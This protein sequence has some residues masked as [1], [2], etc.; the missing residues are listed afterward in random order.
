MAIFTTLAILAAASGQEMDGA[1]MLAKF[2]GKV[3]AAQ[4]LSGSATVKTGE[5]GGGDIIVHFKYKGRD[6]AMLKVDSGP[7]PM[8]MIA[9]GAK[10]WMVFDDS[11]SY[12]EMPNDGAA[13][14]VPGFEGLAG[15]ESKPMAFVSMTKEMLDGASCIKVKAKGPEGTD[16]TLWFDATFENLL[17]ISERANEIARFSN[18]VLGGEIADSDF[19]FSPPAGYKRQEQPAMPDYDAKLLKVGSKAPDW[20]LKMPDGKTMTLTQALK[21]KKALILNFW[22]YG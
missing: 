8:R 7:M 2:V 12:M 11:K 22:F 15:R 20:T 6:K 14:M 9:S 18:L 4:T 3:S 16:R 13:S 17:Q 10:S 5:S 19:V 1:A 21:G